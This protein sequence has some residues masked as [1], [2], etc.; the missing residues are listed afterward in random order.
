MTT[1]KIAV[2]AL[3]GALF[4]SCG[5]ATTQSNKIG[6]LRE[7]ALEQRLVRTEGALRTLTNAD[8]DLLVD[9]LK[10]VELADAQAQVIDAQ[11]E[12]IE[13]LESRAFVHPVA[14]RDLGTDLVG[15]RPVWNRTSSAGRVT[16]SDPVYI[17]SGRA[18]RGVH[19]SRGYCWES[20]EGPSLVIFTWDGPKESY[21][22][23]ARPTMVL[24]ED[25]IVDIPLAPAG[26]VACTARP[27]ES[28]PETIFYVFEKHYKTAG[29]WVYT[30]R[31]RADV[32]S[33]R[34]HSPSSPINIDRDCD[35]R[36]KARMDAW[37][38]ERWVL[39]R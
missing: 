17:Q 23:M 20:K 39:P 26:T 24:L 5:C 32:G 2:L 15:G 12:R 3:L 9:V 27:P 7:A 35:K 1:Q 11:R 6:Y 29:G 37:L 30:P 16:P 8:P 36:E 18:P 19:P 14:T 33:V 38:A 34:A 22:A 31:C 28:N 13:E 4:L 25:Q 21:A 10:E